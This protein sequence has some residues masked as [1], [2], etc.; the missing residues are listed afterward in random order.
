MVESIDERLLYLAPEKILPPSLY[1]WKSTTDR[2]D[3]WSLGCV[4]LEMLTGKK[5]WG[6]FVKTKND[7]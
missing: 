7:L 1:K 4:L 2:S 3:I 5:P 6:G